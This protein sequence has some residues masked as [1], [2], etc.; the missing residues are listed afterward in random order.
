MLPALALAAP[1]C[2]ATAAV[3]GPPHPAPPDTDAGPAGA[4]KGLPATGT[5]VGDITGPAAF[6]P[7]LSLV[8]TSPNKDPQKDS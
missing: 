3:T 5:I 2:P 7:L 4:T 6:H 1:V 8:P